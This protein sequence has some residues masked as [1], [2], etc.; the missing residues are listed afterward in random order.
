[1]PHVTS[2]V[3]IPMPF[4]TFPLQIIHSPSSHSKSLSVFS[5]KLHNSRDYLSCSPLCLQE[6]AQ[7]MLHYN[8]LYEM[9]ECIA[10]INEWI[11]KGERGGKSYGTVGHEANTDI[12]WR[13]ILLNR[14]GF[15]LC[16]LLC[17]SRYTDKYK[18][19]QTWISSGRIHHTLSNVHKQHWTEPDASKR[20]A[21]PFHWSLSPI[22]NIS[23]QSIRLW[24]A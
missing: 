11:D 5:E 18:V 10:W 8:L 20:M 7:H 22:R 13:K 4:C 24:G 21:F 19:W 1:M 6:F 17:R 16:D 3:K 23:S 2:L 12:I 9:S 14:K 15:H